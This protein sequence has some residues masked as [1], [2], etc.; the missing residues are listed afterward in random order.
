MVGARP[1]VHLFVGLHKTGSSAIRFMLDVHRELL[2][3]HGFHLPRATW[4]QYVDGF[5]NGG[6]N[7]LAWEI[8]ARRP[9][10]AEWGSVAALV[11][12]IQDRPGLQ[13]IVFTEDLDFAGPDDIERL[14]EA[15]AAFDVRVV[16]FLRNQIEWLRSMGSEERKFF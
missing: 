10:V 15:F 14:R 5:W 9:I 12:E 1:V 16:V 13:H 2:D 8:C 7:N 4:T 11:A 6:H 3:R